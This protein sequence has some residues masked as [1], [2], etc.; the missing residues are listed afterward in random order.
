MNSAAIWK[1]LRIGLAAGDVRAVGNRV[2]VIA[3][4]QTRENELRVFAGRTDRELHPACAKGVQCVLDLGR[5]IRRRNLL[6][7]LAI[8]VV[9]LLRNGFLLLLAPAAFRR[10]APE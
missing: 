3:Q 10:I 9:F 4:P 5:K 2:K 8:I 1:N 7:Q 6:K